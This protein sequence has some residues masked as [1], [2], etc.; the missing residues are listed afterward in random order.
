MMVHQIFKR[1]AWAI[2]V[3]ASLALAA[4]GKSSNSEVSAQLAHAENFIEVWKTPTCGCCSAW[5]DHLRENGFDV[6]VHDVQDTGAFRA[7]LGMSQDYGSCHSAKIAG[8]AIEGHVP[9]SDIKKLLSQ[10]PDAVGL[11]VPG[12]PMGSPG[13]EH[14]DMPHKRHAYDVLLVGKQG[15]VS[16]YT[17]YEAK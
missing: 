5:V 17:H 4:C 13:M 6:K 16:A 7:A 3:G 10:K 8:Y 15:E 2:L 9:A 14:P 1:S 11:A 12:M